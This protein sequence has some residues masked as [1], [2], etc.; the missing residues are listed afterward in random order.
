LGQLKKTGGIRKELK[1]AKRLK[2]DKKG[3]KIH[4]TFTVNRECKGRETPDYPLSPLIT[5]YNPF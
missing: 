2:G 4:E 5:H 1:K 3:K